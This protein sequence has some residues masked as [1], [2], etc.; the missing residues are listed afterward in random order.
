MLYFETQTKNKTKKILL[1]K[2]KMATGISQAIGLMFS[3]K[4]KFDYALIFDRAYESKINSSIHMFFVFYRI[5]VIFLNSKKDVVDIKK[6]LKP[7]RLYIP[8][9]KAK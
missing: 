4:K 5:T 3:R 7:F 2:H 8:K 1:K 9:R 6:N